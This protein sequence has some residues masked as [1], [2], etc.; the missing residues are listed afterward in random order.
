M[1]EEVGEVARMTVGTAFLLALEKKKPVPQITG[2]PSTPTSYPAHAIISKRD[3][4]G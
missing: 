1:G 3:L 2:N 4:L